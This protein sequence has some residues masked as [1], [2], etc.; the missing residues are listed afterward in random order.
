MLA[1]LTLQVGLI[2]IAGVLYFAVRYVTT[3][4]ENVA[5]RNARRILDLEAVVGLDVEQSLQAAVL[6][7]KGLV[8]AANW[9]YMWAHWPVII[10]TFGYLFF[11]APDEY[12]RF[13]NALF[14]SGAIGLFVFALFPVTPPRLL[15]DGFVDTI[16]ELSSTYRILQ[17]PSLVNEYA[18]VPSFHVGWNVLAAVFL[19]RTPP[20]RRLRPLA[21][22]SPVAMSL[23]VVFTA[24]H[25]VF[26][27]FAG[28]AVST[29][30]LWAGSRLAGDGG[31]SRGRTGRRDV[32]RGN[33]IEDPDLLAFAR[34]GGEHEQPGPVFAEP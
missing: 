31:H 4:S 13:R 26:D 7:S 23:A 9:I 12:R 22:V 15:H 29:F 2:A 24:N 6:G 17:P 18:A 1:D 5:A 14:V 27:A 28:I 11:R 32:A 33:R 10:F 25:Y 20:I 21:V 30:G 34:R 19:W 3:G 8:V 16:T